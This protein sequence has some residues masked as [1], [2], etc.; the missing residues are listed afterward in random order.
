[1]KIL[2]KIFGLT[3]FVSFAFINSYMLVD[4]FSTDGFDL[5]DIHSVARADGEEGEQGGRYVTCYDE[6]DEAVWWWDDDYKRVCKDP[7]QVVCAIFYGNDW[8]SPAT[9]WTE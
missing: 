2:F 4:V 1:M 3:A 7:S 5:N 8:A 6:Y 9:C